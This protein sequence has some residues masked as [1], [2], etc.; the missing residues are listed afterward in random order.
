[1]QSRAAR[2]GLLVAVIAAA[3]VLFVVLQD[4]DDGSD[5]GGGDG[6]GTSAATGTSTT[7]GPR[8]LTVNNGEPVGGVKTLTYSKGDRV[9]LEVRLNQPEEEIHVHGYEIEEPAEKSPVR[10]SF[11]ADLDGI[12]E[13]EVHSHDGGEAQI[14]ELRVNP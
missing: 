7:Q 9:D 4:S 14:A 10:L 1:M 6:T 11:P 12:F 8:I 5:G 2:L 3:V 13:I